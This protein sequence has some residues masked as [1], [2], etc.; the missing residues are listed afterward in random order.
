[1]EALMARH[2][3]RQQLTLWLDGTST[4][5]DEHIDKCEV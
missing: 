4:E 5:F 1:M 2:P 3:N